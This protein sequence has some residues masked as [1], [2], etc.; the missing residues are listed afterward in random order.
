MARGAQG[1]EM[2]FDIHDHEEPLTHRKKK[3]PFF[4]IQMQQSPMH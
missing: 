3:T 2:S 1:A 4:L